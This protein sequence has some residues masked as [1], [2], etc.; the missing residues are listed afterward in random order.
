MK[1]IKLNTKNEL[2]IYMNPV[3]QELLRALSIAQSPLTPKMLADKLRISASGVQHHL[4]KLM[5][6]ELVELDHTEVINGITAK[7]YKAAAVTVQIG[8]GREDETAPQR[9]ALMQESIARTYDGF[10]VRAK[11]IMEREGTKDEDALARWGDVLTGVL[12]LQEK[13]AEELM[14][15]I[16]DYIQ[17]HSCPSRDKAA[18]EYALILYNAED[19]QDSR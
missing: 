8:L 5:S 19:R 1:R 6:L 2:N 4:N 9:Q 11:E 13:E 14:R 15:M 7:F 18:W 3:R 16:Y 12:H 17:K 10:R